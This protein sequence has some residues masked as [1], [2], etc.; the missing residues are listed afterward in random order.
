MFLPVFFLNSITAKWLFLTRAALRCQTAGSACSKWC[1]SIGKH[2]RRQ[3]NTVPAYS[4]TVKPPLYKRNSVLRIKETCLGAYEWAALLPIGLLKRRTSSNFCFKMHPVL[5]CKPRKHQ[6]HE[7]HMLP[8]MHLQAPPDGQTGLS[9]SGQSFLFFIWSHLHQLLKHDNHCCL[10]LSQSPFTPVCQVLLSLL[11]PAWHKTVAA[12]SR[13]Y[14]TAI[15]GLR[16]KCLSLI[17]LHVRRIYSW[18]FP[19]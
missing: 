15:F 12:F 10:S 2:L 4:G 17:T 11:P 6:N 9:Q 1:P 18:V 3:K 7:T 13:R 8:S 16:C 5:F 14:F 19:C